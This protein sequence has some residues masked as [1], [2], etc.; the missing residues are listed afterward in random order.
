M[1]MV[2]F[3]GTSIPEE[4]RHFLADGLPAGVVLF[5]R[6]L[7]DTTQI[8]ELTRELR[9]LWSGDTPPLIAVDQDGGPVR[10]LRS[11]CCPE[12]LA[13]PA[14]AEIAHKQDPELTREAG[15][16]TAV[17]L[18]AQSQSR[19]AA[20]TRTLVGRCLC[21]ADPPSSPSCGSH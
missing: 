4:L 20:G 3:E 7:E 18:A 19:T 5:S 6:N 21:S 14:A 9:S 13:V 8:A 10:R 16:I 1:M 2:G 11:P 17:Q 12:M 15:R